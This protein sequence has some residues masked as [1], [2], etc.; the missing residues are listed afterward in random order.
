MTSSPSTRAWSS[1]AA[2]AAPA[3]A[4]APASHPISGV[5]YVRLDNGPAPRR[6]RAIRDRLIAERAAELVLEDFLGRELQRLIPRRRAD[7]TRFEPDELATIDGALD[8]LAGLTG[9]QVSDLSHEEPAWRTADRATI[10][11]SCRSCPRQV[12][13]PTGR[14]CRHRPPLRH[15]HRRR[16]IW[17][18]EV[19]AHLFDRV[20]ELFGEERG[21]D[22]QPSEYDFVSGPLVAAIHEFADVAVDDYWDVIGDDPVA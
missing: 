13:T 16:V 7:L 9:T 5:E 2:A 3:D 15:R 8:D 22:G 17:R 19:S 20:A 21:P 18:V 14:R 1:G 11:T 4:G 10:P 6:L 12:L